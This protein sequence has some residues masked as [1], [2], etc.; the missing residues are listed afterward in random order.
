MVHTLERGLASLQGG[1]FTEHACQ[2]PPP[3]ATGELGAFPATGRSQRPVDSPGRGEFRNHQVRSVKLVRSLRAI[4]TFTAR[5]GVC[6]YP[7]LQ[8]EFAYK[9]RPPNWPGCYCTWG[10]VGTRISEHVELKS[11][12]IKRNEYCPPPFILTAGLCFLPELPQFPVR[13]VVKQ[14]KTD[15]SVMWCGPINSIYVGIISARNLVS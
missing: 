2:H 11:S 13:L 6:E 8:W 1:H 9:E 3:R 5:S 15:Q 10:Y 14:L 7:V 4:I 12:T